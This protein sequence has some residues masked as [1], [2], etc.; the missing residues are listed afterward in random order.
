MPILSCKICEKEFYKKPCHIARGEGKFCSNKCAGI[1]R[2]KGKYVSCA[3]CENRVWRTPRHLNNSKSKKYFCNKSCQTLWRNSVVYI[4]PNHPNWKGGNFTYRDKLVKA[5]IEQICKRCR[6]DDFR[7]LTVHHIDKNHGNNDLNNLTW[8]CYNC[9][10]LVHKD[11]G[12]Y[13]KFMGAMVKQL[14]QRS[15]AARSRVQIPLAPPKK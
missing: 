6:M 15:V 4:G 5:G 3:I 9:H 2:L 7:L 1:S 13:D 11:K 10:A 8:L 12:E 14:S